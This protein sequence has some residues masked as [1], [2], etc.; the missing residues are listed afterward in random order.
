[1]GLGETRT[2]VDISEK[3]Q[4]SIYCVAIKQRQ[5]FEEKGKQIHGRRWPI[6]LE[7]RHSLR[8]DFYR[9]VLFRCGDSGER[10]QLGEAQKDERRGGSQS[11]KAGGPERT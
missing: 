8:I 10:M 1:M 5:N 2:V 7:C 9:N 3:K 4:Y 11:E 6:S